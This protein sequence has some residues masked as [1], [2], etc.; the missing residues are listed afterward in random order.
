MATLATSPW[1][2]LVRAHAASG[3]RAALRSGAIGVAMVIFA[4]G[5]APSPAYT[6][7]TFVTG[8]VAPRWS[9]AWSDFP[10]PR[11]LL[12][13]LALGF[14]Q[15]GARRVTAG[16]TGWLASLPVARDTGRRA[17]WA[18]ATLGALPVAVFLVLACLVTPP[19]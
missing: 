14:A 7:M 12:A 3:S 6:L 17:A 4:F 8:I 15:V 5:M 13:L 19:L 18:A 2:A 1:W 10:Q 11:L 9:G 16:A